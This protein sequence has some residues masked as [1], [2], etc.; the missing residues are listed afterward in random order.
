MMVVWIVWGEKPIAVFSSEERAKNYIA[1]N[2]AESRWACSAA[3]LNAESLAG[4]ETFA[5]SQ[6]SGRASQYTTHC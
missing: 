6:M 3:C 4:L 2:K 1:R 5:V